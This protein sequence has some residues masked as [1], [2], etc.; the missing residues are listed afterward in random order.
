VDTHAFPHAQVWRLA[1]VLLEHKDILKATRFEEVPIFDEGIRQLEW[2]ANYLT[3]IHF[4]NNTRYDS[5][6]VQIGDRYLDHKVTEG[7]PLTPEE[8]ST[9]AAAFSLNVTRP[10]YVLNNKSGG[11]D[12]L[13]EAVCAFAAL[14]ALFAEVNPQLSVNLTEHATDAWGQLE[15]W[16]KVC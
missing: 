4:K 15:S 1:W 6:V 5:L 13:S 16:I 11:S 3:K 9:P 10:V 8:L 7:R 12:L 14:A 2:A